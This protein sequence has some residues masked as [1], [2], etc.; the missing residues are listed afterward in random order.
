MHSPALGRAAVAL[1]FLLAACGGGD[2]GQTAPDTG[3]DVQLPDLSS[4]DA[5]DATTETDGDTGEDAVLFDASEDASV[6]GD[7][8]DDAD[9]TPAEGEFGAACE[10]NND[11]LSGWCVTSSV[12]PLCTRTC[13]EDCPSGWNCVGITGDV[14]VVFLC[15]PKGDRLCQACTLDTQCGS[16][17]CLTYDEGQRCSAACDDATDCP[18]GYLCEEVHSEL[19]TDKRSFQCVPE[20]GS[21]ECLPGSEGL[22][23]PCNNQNDA[24]LCWGVETC[25]GSDGWSM[26]DAQV[27]EAEL[28]DG[29]DNNCNRFTDENLVLGEC[30]KTNEF[31]TCSGLNVCRGELGV[32]CVAREASLETCN[33]QDDDCNGF[34]DEGFLDA[35]TGLYLD[36]ANCGV[37]GNSCAGFF[38]NAVSGCV[39][40]GGQ[41]RCVVTA[42]AEGF[43]QAGPTTCLP[44][45]A[46]G[47]LPC[48]ADANC[49]VPGNACVEMDGGNFCAEDCGEGNLN[50]RPAGACGDGYECVAMGER[51]VCMPI[52]R[53]CGCL[54]EDDDGKTRPCT[55]SN[56]FGTCAG[57]QECSPHSGGY[58][59]CSARVPG[60][61]ECNGIDD[62]CDGLVDEDIVEPEEACER[63][64]EFGTCGGQWRCDGLQGW[65]CTALT[66]AT[67]TCNYRDDNCNG[68]VDEVFRDEEVD[69][70][71][72]LEH[73]GVCGRNCD[74][75]V[76]F[77]AETACVVENDVPA[78]V[79]V[80]CEEGFFVPPDTNRVCVPTSGARPCSP[81][82]D[83]AQCAELPGGACTNIDGGR[84]CTA[85]CAEDV[86]CGDGY[87]CDAGR[88]LPVSRSCSCLETDVGALR[89][90][91]N[92]NENGTCTGVQTCDPQAT[93]GWSACSAKVPAAEECNGADDN[94]DG[95]IDENLVHN[96]TGC[97]VTNAA[98]S[99]VANYRCEGAGGW[100]C[101]VR[102]PQS[103]LCNYQDDDCNDRIDETFR[104][105]AGR[106]VD[107]AHCG[108]C[109]N[110]CE[111]VIPN[112]TARCAVSGST[113]RCEVAECDPGFYQV[114]PLTCLPATDATC[115]PC[116]TD[117]N[118]PTPG[119]RCLEL[120]G[121]RVCG[122]DCSVGN[123]HGNPAGECDDGYSCEDVGGAMQCVPTSGSCTCLPEDRDTSRPCSVAN[124]AGQCGGSELCVPEEGWLGCTAP[125]PEA[126][127]CNG[128]D[129]DC[130][131]Q[132]D[133]GAPPPEAACAVENGFGRCTGTWTCNGV[134]EWS[135]NASTPTAETCNGFDDDCDGQTD[136]D[137]KVDGIYATDDHCGAC[138]LSCDGALPN[139]TAMCA[140]SNG[141]ARCVVE[142]CAPGYYQA[143]ALTCLPA[144]DAT[145]LPCQTDANCQTPGDRCLQLDGGGYCARDCGEGNRHGLP[146]G[147]CDEGFVCTATGG[148]MQCVPESGSCTCLAADD[149]QTRGCRV[150][151]A[152]GTCFG[153][154]TCESG[155]GWTTC[156]ASTPVA[157][158]CNGRDDDCD[159]LVD[160]AVTHS[161]ATCAATV[162]GVGTCTATWRCEGEDGWQCPVQTPEAEACDF[163]DNNC[164]G[165]I[166]EP[167]RDAQGRYV[168]DQNCGSCGVS[169][170]GAIPN[171]TATCAVGPTGVPRCEV[172][173]CDA[174][175]Y[176]ASP[177]SCA[178]VTES[179]CQPCQVDGDCRTPGDR[180]VDLGGGEKVC[181]RDCSED[182][183]HGEPAGACDEGFTCTN[184]S[185]GPAQCLPAS[186]TCT[187]LPGNDGA[188]RTC[189]IANT[190][191][192]CFGS[193]TCDQ[194]AG[195]VGCSARTP[196]AESC[197]GIDN[198][199]DLFIDEGVTHD[200]TTCSETVAGI[201]TC[202]ATYTCGGAA[203]WQ[204]DAATPTAEQCDF[205]DNNCNG[206]TDETF[207]DASGRYVAL[208]HC[209]SCGVT[210]V[211][212]I[213][214]AEET[215]RVNGNTPRCE[216]LRCDPGYYQAGPTTC[217]PAADNTCAPCATDANCQ[218]PGDRCLDLDG[219]K[220]CGRDC[221]EG[222]VHGTPAGECPDGLVCQAFGAGVS[223]CVPASGS[224]T[225]L[226]DDDGDTRS[227][228]AQNALGTCFGSQS[229]EPANGWTTCDAP[230]PASETCN[231]EDDDCNGQID[232]VAGRGQSC[233]VSNGFG[234]CD[235]IRDCTAEGTL[236]CIGPTP[237]AEI[238]DYADN[239]CDGSV[240]EGFTNLNAICTVGQG[241]CQRIGYRVCT[242]DG[243]GTECNVTAGQPSTEICDGIDNDCD[244]SVDEGPAWA[245]KGDP[246]TDG[247][248]LCRVT[249]VYQCSPD[250][251]GLVC[252]VSAPAPSVANESGL[253]N[254]F[255]DD[256]DGQ[257]DEDFPNKG[258]VCNVGLG[259]CRTFGN[260]VCAANGSATVC[261]ATAG[262]PGSES[263]DLLDN[264]CD[265]QT[266]ETF[267]NA[268]GQ[269]ATDTTCGN[270]FT[271]CEQIYDRPKAYGVCDDSGTPT[272]AL[273]CCRAGDGNAACDGSD[274]YD[275]NLVP[276]DGCEFVLDPD[277]IYVSI[278]DPAAADGPGCGRGPVGTGAG[279]NNY[280]CRTINGG[281]TEAARAGVNRSKVLVADG[282]YVEQ[283][284]LVAGRSLLGGYR[285]DTW[286]RNIAATN[287]TLRG[288]TVTVGH[289]KTVIADGITSN[290]LFEG[291]IVYG[292]T[293]FAPSGNA[294]TFWIRNSSANLT[295]RN[296]LAFGG[297]AGAGL[298]GSGGG[299][300][301]D[302]GH[303]QPGERAILTN[304]HDNCENQSNVP[305]NVADCFD[306]AGNLVPGACGNGGVNTCGGASVS[307]GAGRGAIC[308]DG[309]DRQGTGF[310]GSAASGGG[311]AGT[312]GIGG[313]DRY[314]TDC[315]TFFTSGTATASPGTDG[316]RGEDADGGGGCSSGS[317][318]VSGGEWSGAAGDSGVA[319]AHGGGGGGGG[320]GGGADV[321]EN[322]GDV[323]DALGGSGG[324]GGAGGCGGG[325]GLAGAGGGG[326]FVFFI[327]RTTAST[328]R[329]TLS[330]NIVTRGNGGDGGNGGIGGKGGLGGDGGL[331]GAVAGPW[332]YAM[333]QGG[334]GG[335]G[336]DGGHGGGGGGGCGGASYGVFIHNVSATPNY[337]TANT[338]VLS[339]AG[340]AGGAGGASPGQPGEDGQDGVSADVNW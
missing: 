105:A 297:N 191:G 304:S 110:S 233:Q 311:A 74:D 139:A 109:G 242:A 59:A 108:V 168:D 312:G 157:E 205:L 310:N 272:C 181:G 176:E 92:Q 29:V 15:V 250:G 193:E 338:F 23:R 292:G 124:A 39:N 126:E 314:T 273:T 102:T 319:G 118:C 241:A 331:G 20:H 237:A 317:G 10:E 116:F 302:G 248:G 282:L 288:P 129:D 19:V 281:L 259:T 155:G 336:G 73:C 235:G 308:P 28:C 200:P 30:E 234:S 287:T 208:E 9:T 64:N 131:G 6:P 186:G 153:E 120:D 49:V 249:G 86:D 247:Q 290:T 8:A 33:Y 199:C 221:S 97:E 140:V 100:Q 333:G 203:G 245:D 184:V 254:G 84:F 43:Y 72:A 329:P 112:A 257:T 71:T 309:N 252:S 227:C 296:N 98:G 95:R 154:E 56:R 91:V 27:P 286:E 306:A 332:D 130:D 37:C 119:D 213:P 5:D 201:G 195:W 61:E 114:G 145:C 14:D 334:R 50:G 231:G 48:T 219:T 179:T 24:G 42:C 169:C 299:I 212:A 122:R 142:S 133:E 188:T 34:T 138:G 99:C 62:D 128:L 298:D 80:A 81:C 3:D 123:L 156:S 236:A 228:V 340:G 324:G 38:P 313:T 207:K 244:G 12:G 4:P 44:V 88:C 146:A 274:W 167:F 210:C 35:E 70:Y 57:T 143:S 194:D 197:D 284:T 87:T 101:P 261:D 170:A 165:S 316:G 262:T 278:S 94:C 111:G 279:G 160:E 136:E 89:P 163:L 132:T 289:A 172:A 151:N 216:V 220:V 280:P 180:C 269:Y 270:C 85:G 232:D 268:G 291:F 229:C 144:T 185:G 83:D 325:G 255:D 66:P 318:T 152:A 277:A 260:F 328:A 45:L 127:L 263:C 79:A 276:N 301:G 117:A 13:L 2:A 36:D 190:F 256:C 175:F 243:S 223:Q 217:L 240:D 267:K 266:D 134:D 174:G 225:C 173:E 230:T 52:T 68:E 162:A 161:P 177:L 137:M 67:E 183:V 11:C 305:G 107:D 147:Q 307:G 164:S 76:L 218:T 115:M 224:C 339:G 265:G 295:I 93:P 65:A 206:G 135:C 337:L 148:G 171:A 149:G 258:G 251:S 104:D 294:Y 182:N 63:T 214:N 226:A 113:P 26:C 271:N 209:G 178:A 47:C 335:Q 283:V 46:A 96:P 264:D 189:A 196:A 238:C 192:T 54:D 32:E 106:Y 320:A 330:G 25:L 21:C 40:D 158:D 60:A 285:A 239:D 125:T 77:S 322:C 187:C 1:S 78:C 90:C 53:S 18:T 253:C 150:A 121:A 55:E 69:N 326:S 51:S 22:E 293:T 211:G 202:T 323:D 275:L 16:G 58:S 82:A 166:D 315:G 17:Y 7:S 327:T 222:N 159:G 321:D 246:C 75:V 300:G 141:S 198:D 103:E 215:C 41:A 204:C 31:G 303:G